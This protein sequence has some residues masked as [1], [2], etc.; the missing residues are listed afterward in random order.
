MAEAV[1]IVASA[2]VVVARFCVALFAFKFVL[3][4]CAGIGV[5]RAL[6]TEGIEIGIVAEYACA[7]GQRTG[8]A[9]KIFDIVSG[10]AAVG[11]HGNA[12]AAEENVFAEARVI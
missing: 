4:Q 5:R 10:I 12:L 8:S 3:V 6:D 7:S 9:E 2:E 1:G 11:D